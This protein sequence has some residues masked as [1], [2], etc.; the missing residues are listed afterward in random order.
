VRRLRVGRVRMALSGKGRKGAKALGGK[1]WD[2]V[3]LN[4]R[5]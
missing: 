5:G 4:E 3:Q 1:G 2:G